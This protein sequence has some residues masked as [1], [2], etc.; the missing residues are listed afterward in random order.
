[1]RT[2]SIPQNK[3][4]KGE[5]RV[6]LAR[7]AARSRAQLDPEDVDAHLE[8]ARWCAK[9]YIRTETRS[10]SKRVLELRPNDP[11][12]TSLLRSTE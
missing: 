11:E 2:Y 6:D 3:V 10:L 9:R 1:G 5:N 4:T 12:A 7:R 8:L